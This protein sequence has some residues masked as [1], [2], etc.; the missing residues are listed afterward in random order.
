MQKHSFREGRTAARCAGSV[1]GTSVKKGVIT[2]DFNRHLVPHV[3]L[4]I[5][6]RLC[7]GEI[8]AALEA[9]NWENGRPVDFSIYQMS[10][11]QV[12]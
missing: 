1:P 4:G 9:R 6:A 10:V 11:D 5:E 7:K 2:F 8:N 12:S 3:F